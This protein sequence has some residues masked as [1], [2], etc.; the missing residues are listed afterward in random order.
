[1]GQIKNK[2]LYC[3]K[4]SLIDMIKCLQL[5][6][7]IHFQ[8]LGQKQER[9]TCKQI[10]SNVSTYF[11]HIKNQIIINGSIPT[12]F[13]KKNTDKTMIIT[14]GC[15][16]KMVEKSVCFGACPFL[17]SLGHVGFSKSTNFTMDPNPLRRIEFSCLYDFIGK[18]HNLDLSKQ[19]DFNQF[20]KGMN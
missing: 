1:M 2:C 12:D 19:R 20:K 17:F 7:L 10:V 16:L 18:M 4:Y 3:A 5:F 8:R 6:D 9:R 15:D 13:C 11:L 14:N